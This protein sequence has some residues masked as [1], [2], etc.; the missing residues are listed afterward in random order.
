MGK[1]E[2]GPGDTIIT[3]HP[4]YGGSH[5]PD[6]TLVTPVFTDGK[7]LLGYVVNRAHHA[8]LGGTHPA[9]MPP[10]AN[11]LEEEGVIIE[12]YRLVSSS[13]VDW[14]GLREILGG[15]PWPSRAVE[16]NIADL[17][18]ALAANLSGAGG[19]KELAVKHGPGQVINYMQYLRDYAA[20]RMRLVLD[21]IPDGRY[22][23]REELD[24]NSILKVAIEISKDICCIDFTGTSGVH[25]GN[26]NATSA[27]VNSVVI[28]VLRLLLNEPLPLN[29]GILEPVR[30]ILPESLLNPDFDRSHQECPAIVGGNVEVSQRLTD[31]LLKA[32]GVVACSQGTMNNLMMG[33]D[34]YSYYETICGGCGAGPG[35][36]GA[37]GVHH[38]MTNTRITDPEILEHR[39]PLKLVEFSIRKK[40]GGRGAY[41]GGDGV[42]RI[43]EFN[44]ASTVSILSQHRIVRPYGMQGGKKGKRGRQL[45][46][47]ADGVREKLNGIDG[48]DAHP[49]DRLVL[50]TP[51]GGGWGK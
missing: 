4:A 49:G 14:K 34:S 39:Y 50:R 51:G 3:N 18:A 16:E 33:N 20:S 42:V 40:S 29:E 37:P 30:V 32:F 12:P 13:R 24:D 36:D 28:Y 45:V 21:K 44:S 1:I 35:F 17:N 8:E 46:I 5:L 9:S 26:M 19:L 41:R 31:T 23:A 7:E 47:R 10:D 11:S 38:H 6:V 48:F 2:M 25:Q 43:L 22:E 15:G 27:I